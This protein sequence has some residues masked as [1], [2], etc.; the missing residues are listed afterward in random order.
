MYT[1]YIGKKFLNLYRERFQLSEEYSSKQFFN[2][3]LFP[4]FF[5][6]EKHL[7][8]VHGSS[9]FQKVSKKDLE[10]GKDKSKIQLERLHEDISKNKIS[11]STF[12]GYAAEDIQA[13][14]SGQVTSMRYLIDDEEIYA[15][16]IGQALSIGVAGGLMLIDKEEVLWA[17]FKAWEIYRKYLSQT[18]NLKDRQ[19]ETWNG[20]WLCHAFGKYFDQANVQGGFIFTPEIIQKKLAIKTVDWINVLFALSRQFPN[21][22]LTI[23]SYSLSKTNTTIGFIN[24]YLPEVRSLIRLKEQLYTFSEDGQNDKSFEQLYSTFYTF[25]NACKLGIIGL[26]ALEPK[27]LRQFMP[28]GSMEYAEGKE[29]KLKSEN[30]ILQFQ[31]FKIWIIA[32]LSNKKE[33]NTLAEKVA[34][35]LIHFEEQSHSSKSGRG[36]ATSSRL[37]DQLKSSKTLREFIENLTELLSKYSEGAHIFKQV[38]DAVIQLPSDLFPLFITLIRFEYQYKKSN[39][40]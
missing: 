39:H 36:K 31:I 24:T 32:M 34:Q 22:T 13:T 8:H 14:S 21:E 37:S 35:A 23:Y 25:K 16:W 11:G 17:L 5:N 4:I 12:V 2:E 18:P 40:F 20:L 27:N 15:S 29:L 33:L 9:F 6:D 7:M 3:V 10:K 19:I 26:K 30:E 1:S 38:K 28:S